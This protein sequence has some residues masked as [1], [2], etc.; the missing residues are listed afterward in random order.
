MRQDDH[1]IFE[2][3][4]GKPESA[5]ERKERVQRGWD[6]NKNRWAKWKMENPE[7]A[8]KHAAKKQGKSENAENEPHGYP[9][10][11]TAIQNLLINQL[12]KHGFTLTKIHHAD[13]DRDKY[14]TV[15][16]MRSAGPMHNV[17]EIGGMGEINGEPYNDYLAHIKTA[18]EDDADVMLKNDG[19]GHIQDG[20]EDA[21]NE[22]V[23][24]VYA[25]NP[26]KPGT[27]HGAGDKLKVMDAAKKY[28]LNAHAIRQ[29][30]AKQTSSMIKGLNKNYII[31]LPMG[32]PA[33]KH[34]AEDAEGVSAAFHYDPMPG[35]EK[36]AN[37][38]RDLL[39]GAADDEVH[40]EHI[41]KMAQTILGDPTEY[42]KN[43]YR[44]MLDGL[45][46]LL[47][48]FIIVPMN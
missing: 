6:A 8:A 32:T 34:H 20:S 19:A 23:V 44:K 39:Q 14:P 7:A 26:A 45:I 37:Q 5:D 31:T 22:D 27:M 3:F 28:N 41:I 24:I 17:V 12:K 47:N 30:L 33:L 15:F 40:T 29:S 48:R 4:K 9:Q 11:I 35:L 25:E 1:L 42:D 43:E 46:V 18:S 13:K 38:I 2:A 36:T 21:E 10:G 16:M